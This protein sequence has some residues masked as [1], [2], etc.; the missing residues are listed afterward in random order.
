MTARLI[1]A[2]GS[3]I[4]QQILRD[5]GIA[6]EIIKSDVDEDELKQAHRELKPAA[7][8]VLLANAK[9]NQVS[10]AH[11]EDFVLGAD[12][13]MELDGELLDK[14]PQRELARA[15]L[16]AMRGTSHQLHS[17]LALVC[18]NKTVWE[19]QQSSTLWVRPFSDAFLDIY[20]ATA[21]EELTASVGAYAYEGL[22][23]QLF[24]R[25]DGEFH[26]ILGLPLLPLLKALRDLR[27]IA[28]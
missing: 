8:A 12:Q 27:V 5:A 24:E 26:A 14:L 15:R 13:T 21:G 1:L 2:S 7:M 23:A 4:R 10:S 22:G 18:A 6:F 20:L 3:H 16:T 9:A 17:G 25:V 19:H 28:S 11:P